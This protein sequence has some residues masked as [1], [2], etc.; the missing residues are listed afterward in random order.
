MAQLFRGMKE[1]ARS[2]P[3]IGAG[4]RTLSVRPGI[5]VSAQNADEMVGPGE[6]EG[7]SVTQDDPMNLPVHRRPPAFQGQGRDP[8]WGIDEADLGPDLRYHPEA[9]PKR[10]GHGFV[11]PARPMTLEAYQQALARTQSRW[12]KIEQKPAEGSWSYEDR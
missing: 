4:A 5:D 6:E 1:D 9:K 11:E 10:P 8:V 2:R 7:L 12:R 3:E